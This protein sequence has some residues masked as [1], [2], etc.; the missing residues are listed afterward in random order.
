M[1][2]SKCIYRFLVILLLL[3]LSFGEALNAQKLKDYERE[4]SAVY[5]LSKNYTVTISAS[6]IPYSSNNLYFPQRDEKYE[7]T[8]GSGFLFDNSGHIVT[9]ASVIGNGTLFR[10][11]FADGT[12]RF[13]DLIGIDPIRSIAVLKV[14]SPPFPPPTFADSDNLTP[15]HWIGLIGNSFGIFPSFSYGITSG[16]DEEGLLLVTAD[17]SPGGAGG[18]AINSDGLAVGMVAFKLTE[19]SGINSIQLDGEKFGKKD[20]LV[21]GNAKIDLP[22]GGYS[23]VIPSNTLRQIAGVIISGEANH[24][25]F[26]GV[27]PEDLDLD[28]AKRVFNINFGVYITDVQAES[29]AY[30][31]GIRE[32]DILIKYNWHKITSSAQLRR[33]IYDTDPGIEVDIAIMRG[34]RIRDL[35]A[36]IGNYQTELSNRSLNENK[37]TQKSSKLKSLP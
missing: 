33:L 13:A 11:T 32:G 36:T 21:L 5:N 24:G 17:I 1:L 37:P 29:P 8:I 9:T 23:L 27:V 20:P 28:W 22:V 10:I 14:N 12:T 26:F 19:P 7:T 30:Q 18:L 35:K 4:L 31:A 2:W 25:G 3:S 15:G 6:V 16:R 34:G